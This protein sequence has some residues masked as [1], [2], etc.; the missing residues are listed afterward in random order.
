MDGQA[1]RPG[2]GAGD[3]ENHVRQY[4]DSAGLRTAEEGS[5]YGSRCPT[6]GGAT[7]GA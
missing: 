4:P 6:R 5:I 2:D 1:A 3:G 7:G